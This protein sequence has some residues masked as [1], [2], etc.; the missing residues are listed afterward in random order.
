M[1]PDPE[2]TAHLLPDGGR[3]SVDTISL[4]EEPLQELHCDESG[5]ATEALLL[6]SNG[7]GVEE[8][9]STKYII[10]LTCGTFG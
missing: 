3:I 1:G 8:N 6:S 5:E 2:T 7:D 4:L 10:L 9:V